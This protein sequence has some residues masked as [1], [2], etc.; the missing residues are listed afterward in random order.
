MQVRCACFAC[1]SGRKAFSGASTDEP[2]AIPSLVWG[3]HGARSVETKE[4]RETV[5]AMYP[6]PELTANVRSYS[7]LRLGPW[8]CSFSDRAKVTAS[9]VDIESEAHSVLFPATV[10]DTGGGTFEASPLCPHTMMAINACMILLH[11]DQ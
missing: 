11:Q 2:L 1:R 8:D 9:V 3:G 4:K 5:S 6:T 10:V 7:S